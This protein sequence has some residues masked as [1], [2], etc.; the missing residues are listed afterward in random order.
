MT[1][2]FGKPTLSPFLAKEVLVNNKNQPFYLGT[3]NIFSKH[4]WK[5]LQSIKA[6]GSPSPPYSSPTLIQTSELKAQ[7]PLI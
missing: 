5:K 4:S 2:K 7:H 6:S 3:P 1:D